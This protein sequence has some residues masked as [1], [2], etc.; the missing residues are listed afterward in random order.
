MDVLEEDTAVRALGCRE[1]WCQE[2]SWSN[3][4][5]T[6][7]SCGDIN[8]PP[9]QWAEGGGELIMSQQGG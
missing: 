8:R 6:N 4:S 9:S 3:S 7:S 2:Q 1:G 5:I